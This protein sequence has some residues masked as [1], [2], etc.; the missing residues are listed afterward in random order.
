[1]TA[2]DTW[3]EQIQGYAR[4]QVLMRNSKVVVCVPMLVLSCGESHVTPQTAPSSPSSASQDGRAQLAILIPQDP[5]VARNRR[6]VPHD[7]WSGLPYLDLP[8]PNYDQWDLEQGNFA[9]VHV[10]RFHD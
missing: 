9:P 3:S 6:F 1:M 8:G 5:A 2:I 10:E 4:S 7:P